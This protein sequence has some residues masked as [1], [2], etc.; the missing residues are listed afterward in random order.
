[1]RLDA[2]TDASICD[3]ITGQVPQSEVIMLIVHIKTPVYEVVIAAHIGHFSI[4]RHA[5]GARGVWVRRCEHSS[6]T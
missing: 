2:T 4:R 6:D 1:M 3:G 5:A